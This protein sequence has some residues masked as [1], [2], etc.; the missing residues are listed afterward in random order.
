MPRMAQTNQPGLAKLARRIRARHE[1]GE[2]A[3]RK[4]LEHYRA[5]GDA[6]IEAR[7]E[8]VRLGLDWLQWLESEV[9]VVKRARAYHYIAFA[10]LL[11]TRNLTPAKQEEEWRRISGN[12]AKPK[13]E[14]AN[15]APKPTIPDDGLRLIGGGEPLLLHKTVAETF[16]RWVEDVRRAVSIG[17]EPSLADLIVEAMSHLHGEECRAY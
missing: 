10:T 3:R 17:A 9:K 6:L 2:T 13:W 1:A 5:A 8:C 4:G 14:T 11:V 16:D 15:S 7:A 12:C